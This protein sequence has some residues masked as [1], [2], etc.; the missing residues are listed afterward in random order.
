MA[1]FNFVKDFHC[2]VEMKTKTMVEAQTSNMIF[3]DLRDERRVL[4]RLT[5]LHS[6]L[7]STNN[8]VRGLILQYLIMSFELQWCSQGKAGT[9]ET[10]GVSLSH[11]DSLAFTSCENTT[12]F[13]YVFT[14]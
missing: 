8:H 13:V 5:P 1:R 9:D 11:T 10:V 7:G 2:T 14:L 4:L 12:Q 6:S 3:I